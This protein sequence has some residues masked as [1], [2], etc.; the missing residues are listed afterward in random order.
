MEE[1]QKILENN[2]H[3]ILIIYERIIT[4][5]IKE[6]HEKLHISKIKRERVLEKSKQ[7]WEKRF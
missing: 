7:H 6:F 1:K 3:R 2:K 4:K 5:E